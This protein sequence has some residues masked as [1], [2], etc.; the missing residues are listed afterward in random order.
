MRTLRLSIVLLVFGSCAALASVDDGGQGGEFLRFGS[1]ARSFGM[2]GAFIGMADDV[3]TLYWN[4]AGLDR[5]PLPEAT[6]MHVFLFEDTFYDFF[7]VAYPTERFGTL[8]LGGVILR[9]GDFDGRNSANEP[10]GSFSDTRTGILASYASSWRN[11]SFGGTAKLV[12]QSVSSYSGSGF[13]L[14]F[15]VLWRPAPYFNGGFV[16]QNLLAPKVTL[17]SDGDTY[18][19]TYRFGGALFLA[20]RRF[21]MIADLTKTEKQSVDVQTGAEWWILPSAAIRAGF[22]GRTHSPSVGASLRYRTAQLDYALV[23]HPVLGTSNRILLT[24]RFGEVLRIV[25]DDRA[26]S[27]TIKRTMVEFSVD[28]RF[29][30]TVDR[31]E[32]TVRNTG[33]ELI[34]RETGENNLPEILIWDGRR[35]SDNQLAAEGKYSARLVVYDRAGIRYE[36]GASVRLSLEVPEETVPIEIRLPEGTIGG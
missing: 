33:G 35:D 25:P 15:G 24:W 32:L 30:A 7:G 3:S 2:G 12:S 8:G 21:A 1:S 36:S 19:R 5:L 28:R 20:D 10:T 16:V 9:S 6:F 23:P 27:P 18:A 14:D 11:L 22:D 29:R 26:F 31:W 17:A 4:P 13:G 34:H